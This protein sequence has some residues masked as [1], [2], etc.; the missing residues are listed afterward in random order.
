M[1][2]VENLFSYSSEL[3][4]GLKLIDPKVFY[5]ERGFFLES[6][7]QEIFNSKIYPCVKF[8]QDNHSC[9]SRGTL[10]G[11]HYQLPPYDQGK[12]IRCIHGEIFDVAIDLRRSSNTFGKWASVY[13]SSENFKQLFIPAGF[14]HGFLTLSDKAEVLYKVTNYWNKDAERS[15]IWNDPFLKI[16]WPLNIEFQ[17]SNKDALAP[18][19]K[20]L[21]NKDLFD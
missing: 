2:K 11:L 5:D 9:S 17:L 7:N 21:S 3:I 15:I 13:L 12:L 8:F 16:D 1:I 19:F 18:T 10:R 20:D 4:Q 14:A 6:W